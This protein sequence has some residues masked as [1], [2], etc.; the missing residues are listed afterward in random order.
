MKEETEGRHGALLTDRLIP[1]LATSPSPLPLLAE[2]QSRAGDGAQ[3]GGGM[4]AG[5]GPSANH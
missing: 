1:A 4:E 2:L 3:E 5:L